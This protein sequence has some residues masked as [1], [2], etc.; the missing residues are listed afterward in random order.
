[1]RILSVT[2]VF[3]LESKI[4]RQVG[5][6]DLLS[7]MIIQCHYTNNSDRIHVMLFLD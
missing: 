1:M 4:I 2:P 5:R 6:I 3:Q 7:P